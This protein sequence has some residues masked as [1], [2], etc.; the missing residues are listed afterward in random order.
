MFFIARIVAAMLTGSWGSY[1]T[2][3]TAE[4]TESRAGGGSP[5]SAVRVTSPD[6][7]CCPPLPRYHEL[8][9]TALRRSNESPRPR[10]N[11]SL[12]DW[13]A[14]DEAI[15]DHDHRNDEQ[16][17]DQPAPDVHYEEPKNPKDEENYRDGPKHDGILERSELLAARQEMSQAWRASEPR[18]RG[19]L[20]HRRQHGNQH[21]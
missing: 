11:S 2:T 10:E 13:S 18:L 6:V 9:R 17:M 21:A 14:G 20:G 7:K 4:R 1:R 16:K 3:R 8:W 15:Y 12:D 19:M 5:R